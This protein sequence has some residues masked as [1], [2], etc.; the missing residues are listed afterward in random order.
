MHYFCDIKYCQFIRNDI[1]IIG[2]ANSVLELGSALKFNGGGH[3][4][5]SLFWE[6]LTPNSSNTKISGNLKIFKFDFYLI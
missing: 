3:I 1:Y 2:D 6:M 4:N 5:H